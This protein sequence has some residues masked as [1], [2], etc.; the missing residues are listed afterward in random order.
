MQFTDSS[1]SHVVFYKEKNPFA[2]EYM[3]GTGLP[4]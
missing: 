1:L 3:D 4:N 2:A